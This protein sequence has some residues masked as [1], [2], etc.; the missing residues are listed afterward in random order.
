MFTQIARCKLTV[1][2]EVLWV[3]SLFSAT[4][5]LVCFIKEIGYA[6]LNYTVENW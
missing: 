2:F 3:S 5:I 4:S 6:S 1:H